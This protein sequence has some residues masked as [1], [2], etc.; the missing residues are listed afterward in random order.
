MFKTIKQLKK[1]GSIL[2]SLVIFLMLMGMLLGFLKKSQKPNPETYYPIFLELMENRVNSSHVIVLGSIVNSKK[3]S[4][5]TVTNFRV[6]KTFFNRGG[7]TIV[8]DQEIKVIF[9]RENFSSATI[10]GPNQILFLK[11]D[12]AIINQAYSIIEVVSPTHEKLIK[13]LILKKK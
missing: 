1:T 10:V 6:Q 12:H 3:L 7:N 13:N 11:E 4:N 2:V 8:E 5:N 9:S